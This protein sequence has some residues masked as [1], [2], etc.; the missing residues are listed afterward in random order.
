MVALVARAR[1]DLDAIYLSGADAQTLRQAK[2][3]R[4]RELRDRYQAL[5]REPGADPGYDKWFAGELNNAKLGSLAAYH[6][7]VGTFLALLAQ[8][9][10]DLESFYDAAETIAGLES[11]QR[12]QVLAELSRQPAGRPVSAACAG[13]STAQDRSRY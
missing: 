1:E 3:Q 4:L 2:Q 12:E 5:R 8:N 10:N 9:C 6:T 7:H 13:R 11:G